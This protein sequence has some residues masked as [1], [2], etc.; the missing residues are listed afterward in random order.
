MNYEKLKQSLIE[1]EGL[2]LKVYTCPA[3][4]QTIGVGRNL[5]TRGITKDEALRMLDEDIERCNLFLYGF[6]DHFYYVDDCVKNVLIQMVFN[7]GETGFKKFQKMIKAV[8]E[9]DYETASKEMLDSKWH[10]DF[11]ALR[12]DKNEKETR[13]Y[14]LALQMRKGEFI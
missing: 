1:N 3:G 14:K 12:K 7:L 5:E 9:R 13:S 8:N 4:Y 6:F 10:R 11:V 2:K